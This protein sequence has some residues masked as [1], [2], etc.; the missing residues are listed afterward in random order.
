MILLMFL[1]KIMMIIIII[2]IIIITMMIIRMRRRGITIPTSI[3]VRSITIPSSTILEVIIVPTRAYQPSHLLHVQCTID[4]HFT[5]TINTSSSS[6]N[7]MHMIHHHVIYLYQTSS[8][9]HLYSAALYYN[10]TV[11]RAF[12]PSIHPC[13][14]H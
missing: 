8:H 7:I 3:I 2:I 14:H 4:A 5:P 6:L 9:I 12:N 11:I 13:I 1:F 10:R